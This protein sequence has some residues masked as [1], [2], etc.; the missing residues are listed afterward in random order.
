MLRG[1]VGHIKWHHY[2]AAAI[3][4]YA[5]TPVKPGDGYSLVGT[6]IS[7]NAFNLTQRPLMFE[8]S[9]KRGVWR[10]PIVQFTIADNG[11]LVAT[12]G[13]ELP[14]DLIHGAIR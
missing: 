3:N 1:I 10:W 5:V 4:G 11:R 8:A 13:A 14:G 2:T 7:K 6:V 9:H 12:L